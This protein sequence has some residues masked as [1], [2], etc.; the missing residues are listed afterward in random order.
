[1]IHLF[2]LEQCEN[3]H[4]EVGKHFTKA[5][6]KINKSKLLQLEQRKTILDTKK[7]VSK[8]IQNIDQGTYKNTNKTIFNRSKKIK[9]KITLHQ[10]LTNKNDHNGIN[11][12]LKC[13]MTSIILVLMMYKKYQYERNASDDYTGA[14]TG[15]SIRETVVVP[16]VAASWLHLNGEVAGRFFG[17]I[18]VFSAFSPPAVIFL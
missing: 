13:K 16:S 7:P 1:M 17:P 15:A 3:I 6:I 2:P 4:E 11:Y 5:Y 9:S 8:E 12:K 14:A 10:K 18:L